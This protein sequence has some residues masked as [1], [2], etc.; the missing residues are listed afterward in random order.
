M[1][2]RILVADDEEVVCS[3]VCRALRRDPFELVAVGSGGEA[4]ARLETDDYDLLV[5]DLLM[6]RMDGLELLRRVRD[7]GHR[8]QTLVITG[9]PTVET[10]L[11]AKR[12]GASEYVTKPFTRK[13]L[14]SAVVRALRRGDVGEGASAAGRDASVDEGLGPT[15]YIPD[16]TW[17]RLEPEG[18]VRIGMAFVFAATVGGV[19]DISLPGRGDRLQQGTVFAVVRAEDGIEHSLHAPLS[20]R[21][22]LPNPHVLRDPA[23]SGRAPESDGWLVRVEPRNLERELRNLTQDQGPAQK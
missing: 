17:A 20:G 15:Y 10:A 2:K 16:H 21:V 7:A 13:E 22:L 18:D 5:T 4:L 14:R 8:V 1:K 9:Y 23:L 12:L 11:E 3:A 6:P 19:A